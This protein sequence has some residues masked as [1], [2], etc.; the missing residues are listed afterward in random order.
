MKQKSPPNDPDM[1]RAALYCCI[2][3]NSLLGSTKLGEIDFYSLAN[4]KIFSLM[5]RMYLDGESVDY[6]TLAAAMKNE[7]IYEECGGIVY[8]TSFA[9]LEPAVPVFLDYQQHLKELTARRRLKEISFGL[10]KLIDGN[11]NLADDIAKARL[12]LT[13][14]ETSLS[15][16]TS[17]IASRVEDWVRVTSGK[18]M[19]TELY[20]DLCLTTESNKKAA[21]MALKRLEPSGLVMKC[22]EKRGCWMAVSDEMQ[23]INFMEVVADEYR[24]IW[25]S[26]FPLHE[27]IKLFPGSLV[28]IAG[29]PNCGKTALMFNLARLNMEAPHV[30]TIRYFNSEMGE[31]E[32]RERLDLFQSEGVSI[33]FWNN[34]KFEAWER[35]DDFGSVIAPDGLNLIDYLEI[36]EEH[37]LVAKYLKQI[38]QRL[39]KGVAVVALQKDPGKKHAKG[40]A[41]ISEKPRLEIHMVSTSS[42]TAMVLGQVQLKKVKCPRNTKINLNNKVFK[43]RLRDGFRFISVGEPQAVNEGI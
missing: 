27:Y 26:A 7:G 23:R 10:A 8:V 4:A 18:F 24:V 42:N 14:L 22:G 1:E 3:K 9:D 11:G 39:D 28:I 32:F 5:S 36:Y 19:V 41:A 30:K 40:G 38:W 33:E 6:T 15:D 21:Q 25:P 20:K 35:S 12:E 31:P 37:Y 34:P 2:M 17:S 13:E 43:Y 29:E 16:K